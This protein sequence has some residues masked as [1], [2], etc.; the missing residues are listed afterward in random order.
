MRSEVAACFQMKR[1][2]STTECVPRG[3]TGSR[4]GKWC[5][6]SSEGK[7]HFSPVECLSHTRLTT[8]RDE[9]EEEC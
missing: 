9:S 7:Y 1:G 6:A 8:S 2:P 4:K 5:P 3:S